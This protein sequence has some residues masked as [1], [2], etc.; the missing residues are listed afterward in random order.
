M[1]QEKRER[2][3][4]TWTK[5]TE[6][7]GEATEHELVMQ[8]LEPMDKGRKCFR[9]V[10]DV[11]VERTVGETL[12]AVAKNKQNLEDAIT[13]LNRTLEAQKKDLVEFQT[14]YKITVRNNPSSG[15]G[16]AAREDA[17]DAPPAAAGSSKQ[18]GGQ[19]VLVSKS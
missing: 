2:L 18:Q 14:K 4:S 19:G 12:P 8:T 9:L 10:G 15:G 1:F 5:I 13:S 11:L 6:L 7:A 16:A 17:D 3:N